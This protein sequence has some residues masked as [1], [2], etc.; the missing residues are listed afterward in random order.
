M[1]LPDRQQV[2]LDQ[3]EQVLQAADPR[4]KTMFAI[5]AGSASHEAMP[6]TE[7][8]AGPDPGTPGRPGRGMRVRIAVISVI[9][10]SL[11]SLF[12]YGLVSTSRECPG[13]P[14]DQTVATAA[15]RYAACS[16]STD[17]WSKGGR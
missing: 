17:A 14:S 11:L 16:H 7:A 4:L 13:L 9:A 6:D 8:I 3:I 15:V 5:F 12:T 2:I 10:L 1:S